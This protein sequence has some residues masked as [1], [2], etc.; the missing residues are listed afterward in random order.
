MALTKIVAD[1][2]RGCLVPMVMG[3]DGSQLNDGLGLIEPSTSHGIELD[4]NT[5]DQNPRR[6][7]H[8]PVTAS[9]P[10]GIGWSSDDHLSLS[11]S[12][13]WHFSSPSMAEGGL[14]QC[15]FMD[16]N[17]TDQNPRRSNHLPVTASIPLRIGWSS[18]DHLSLSLSLF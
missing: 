15:V 5:T 7:N 2:D 6:S 9:F 17:T 3:T 13:F 1:F 16:Q 10:L 12:L 4:Q 8:L 18:D 11:L 14:D